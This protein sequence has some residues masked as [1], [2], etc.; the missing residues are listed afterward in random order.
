MDDLI[1]RYFPIAFP[2]FF[3]GL[4][5]CV[6]SV[7]GAMSGLYAL[8]DRYPDR[9]EQ[10]QLKLRHLSGTMGRGVNMSGILNIDV[11]PSGL[12]MSVWKL[13]V[14]FSRNVFVPWRDL[15]VER[16]TMFG[17]KFAVLTFGAPAGGRLRL[18]ARIAD[19][20]ARAAPGRWP[21][22]GDFPKP[23]AGQ[24]FADVAKEWFAVTALAA[25]FFVAA[26]RLLAHGG[27]FPPLS[28]AVLFPG[29]F[30]GVVFFVRFLA[31]LER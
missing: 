3:L 22:R 18:P 15:G 19:R 17:W 14:P 8:A 7:L 9:P 23:T 12:R 10:A 29:V 5:V 31:R 2:V 13:F 11:C 4:W 27:A 16:K 30:F 26:P 25:A 6:G 28:I 24:V 20:I 21:E 1:W